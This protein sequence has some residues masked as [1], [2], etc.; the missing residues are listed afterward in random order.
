M[1]SRREGE[2]LRRRQGCIQVTRSRD[3]VNI[4][5]KLVARQATLYDY[6]GAVREHCLILQNV[7]TGVTTHVVKTGLVPS[8]QM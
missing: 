5:G 2:W 1:C 6:T 3:S 4:S 7:V 8:K